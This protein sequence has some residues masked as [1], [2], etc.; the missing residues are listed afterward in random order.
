MR[1]TFH[2]GFGLL[3]ALA[4]LPTPATASGLPATL[5]DASGRTVTV[6]DAS[7]IVALGGTVTEILYALGLEAAVT[8]IDVT[9]TYPG[10]RRRQ[11]ERRLCPGAVGRGRS[12]SRPEPDPR[13]R[14]RGAEGGRRRARARFRALPRRAEGS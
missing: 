6:T 8:G 9:S 7:R 5:T 2:A 13:H 12:R 1:R 4:T 10:S 11:A 3:L 14:R